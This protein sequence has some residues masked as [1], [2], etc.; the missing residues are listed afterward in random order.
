[1]KYIFYLISQCGENFANYYLKQDEDLISLEMKDTMTKFANDVIANTAFGFNCDSLEDPE[2]EFYLMGQAATDFTSM[3]MRLVFMFTVFAPKL[4]AVIT[5]FCSNPVLI[6]YCSSSKC[7][8]LHQK[9]ILS[10]AKL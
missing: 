3:R 6:G 5:F 9:F 1:M 4:L 2:N 8:Y 7:H 10:F